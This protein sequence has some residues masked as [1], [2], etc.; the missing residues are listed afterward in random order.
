MFV[1]IFWASFCFFGVCVLSHYFLDFLLVWLQS[2]CMFFFFPF[3]YDV[4]AMICSCRHQIRK[5]NWLSCIFVLMMSRWAFSLTY[6][7]FLYHE[8]IAKPVLFFIFNGF[9]LEGNFCYIRFAFG[10]W[11]KG[12]F[13]IVK[14]LVS[15]LSETMLGIMWHVRLILKGLYYGLLIAS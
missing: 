2:L 14:F 8:M 15:W 4:K 10:I 9:A 5:V 11:N 3:T 7:Y 6:L 1:I 13:L 12:Y